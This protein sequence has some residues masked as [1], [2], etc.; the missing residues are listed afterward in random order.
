MK[1]C[2]FQDKER[3][4]SGKTPQVSSTWTTWLTDIIP[5]D[6]PEVHLGQ[7]ACAVP[8]CDDGR[9]QPHHLPHIQARRSAAVISLASYVIAETNLQSRELTHEGAQ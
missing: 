6:Y 5:S 3:N 9:M 1:P 4:H 7:Q 2:F 8:G